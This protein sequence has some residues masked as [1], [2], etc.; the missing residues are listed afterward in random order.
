LGALT[1]GIGLD[2]NDIGK[3]NIL[4]TCSYVAIKNDVYKKAY[5]GLLSNK[6]KNKYYKVYK[7]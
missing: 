3:I 5:E 7:R 2:K 1:A 6:M 4:P